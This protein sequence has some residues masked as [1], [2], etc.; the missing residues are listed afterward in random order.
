MTVATML[1]NRFVIFSLAGLLSTIQIYAQSQVHRTENWITNSG[2]SRLEHSNGYTMLSGFFNQVGPYTGSGVVTDLTA[3]TV[4]D[5][6]MPK[7]NGDVYTSIADGTGG[8]YVG[9]YFDGIDT[10]KI[11][12]LAHIKADKTV[13]RNWKPNPDNSPSDLAL[14]GTTLYVGGYFT[15]MD[16]QTRNYIAAFD[17]TTGNL[18]SWNPNASGGVQSIEVSGTSVY[19]GGYFSSIGGQSR[20][21]L[22]AIN[23]STGLA[24]SW[25]PVVVNTFTPNVTAMAI[26]ATSIYIGGSFTAVGGL[27]RVNL[28]RINLSTGALL[29]WVANTNGYVYDIELS[30]GSLYVGGS[31]TTV[32]GISRNSFAAVNAATGGVMSWNAGLDAS[33]WVTDISI[34]GNSIYFCGYFDSVNASLRNGVA[35]VDATTASVLP[36]SPNPNSNS[37]NT[38]SATA[39][40]VFLGGT[41][42]GV[43]WV[44]RPGGFALLNDATDQAWPFQLD[45]NGGVVNTIAV[46]D[47]TLYIGGQFTM[48]NKSPRRNLAAIDLSTG[49][50]LPWDPAVFGLG[51]TDPAVTVYSIKIKDNL[52]Y[53]GG[54][55]L[56]VNAVTTIRPGLAAIDLTTGVVN[57]WAP[58]VGD[59]KTTNEFVYSLDIAG[60]TVY[61]AG[62]F[63]LL[64]GNQPRANL[65]AIDATSGAVLPWAP[66]SNGVVEKIRVTANTAYVVGEFGNGVGGVIRLYRVAALN[67]GT[68]TATTWNPVFMNGAV[69]D[70]AIGGADLYVGGYFDGVG[71]QL[72][73]GLTSF[74]LATGNLTTW[75]PDAGTNSDGQYDINALSTSPSKLYISGIFDYLGMEN[76]RYYGEYNICP[77]APTITANGSILTTTSSGSLQW[78]EN[79]SPAAGATSQTYEINLL[80][81]GIYAVET[82]VNGCTARSADF[83]YIITENE[84]S[85]DLDLKVYPNPVHEELSILLPSTSGSVD[86]KFMDMTGRT[87]KNIS[88]GG[89]EHHISMREFD[90][91]PY[92]LLIQTPGQ[93]QV[94]KIIKIN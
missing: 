18:T 4:I 55:F 40:N 54:K 2:I 60:N 90:E 35:A 63:S 57:S 22:A 67:L 76:R 71:T 43:N 13:D 88:G 68:N 93:K 45:L 31:F 20:T 89:A 23:A 19:V 24:T 87:I 70:I 3:G 33:D 75:N 26:D 36:W 25:A 6:A 58:I 49:Q 85:P 64:A 48:I 72:R 27:P 86:F 8:W 15:E 21:G 81:Y 69:N 51:S 56:A 65:A 74:S 66:V 17:T 32:N 34:T 12:N 46:K 14:S 39:T 1:S 84:S 7:I 47:N 29:A 83:I 28:A 16:G 11:T 62:S 73:P 9:G 80:E 37:V 44:N 41:M 42:N 53:V 77:P 50:V 91:G 78:Y 79:N 52:L 94:R 59:G 5:A 61:A 10:V 82:T 30:G 38:V 92:L